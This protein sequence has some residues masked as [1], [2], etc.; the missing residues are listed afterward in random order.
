MANVLNVGGKILKSLRPRL[1]ACNP[2]VALIHRQSTRMP[3]TKT[4]PRLSTEL[5]LPLLPLPQRQTSTITIPPS[6]L[7]ALS[8]EDTPKPIHSL[9][10]PVYENIYPFAMPRP[11]SH[12]QPIL[13]TIALENT[14]EDNRGLH[15]F[16]IY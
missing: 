5:L 6:S 10:S 12:H 4:S 13:N 1:R 3:P 14:P 15:Y 7:N 2:I 16:S 11:V 9:F 8:L